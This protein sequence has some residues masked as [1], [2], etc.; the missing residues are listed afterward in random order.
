MFEFLIMEDPGY[1]FPKSSTK[2][3]LFDPKNSDPDHGAKGDKNQHPGLDM[4]RKGQNTLL[5]LEAKL[6]SKGET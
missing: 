5:S 6:N 1:S 4:S 2:E 3:R